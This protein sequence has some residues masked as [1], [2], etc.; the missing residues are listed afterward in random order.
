MPNTKDDKTI[1]PVTQGHI[2]K[3]GVTDQIKEVLDLADISTVRDY[4]IKDWLIPQ[5]KAMI[6]DSIGVYFNTG[7]KST[8]NS[9]R[10]TRLTNIPYETYSYN[11]KPAAAR[12]KQVDVA[13]KGFPYNDIIVDTR[14]EGEEVIAR[15][16]ECIENDGYVTVQTA[17]EL[18][19][20]RMSNYQANSYGWFDLRSTRIKK[21]YEGYLLQFPKAVPLN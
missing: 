20:Q 1:K 14:P 13:E 8:F 5:A 12:T 9:G 3:K 10:N 18:V 15:M 6:L 11:K 4:V 21:V 17:F 2:R 16:V 7:R 19:G